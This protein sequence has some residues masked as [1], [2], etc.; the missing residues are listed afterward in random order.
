MTISRLS[1][2]NFKGVGLRQTVDLAPITLLFGPNSAGKSTIL[3]ALNYLNDI[4]CHLDPGSDSTHLGEG[5]LDLGGFRQFVHKHDLGKT[6]V[7]G[8]DLNLDEIDLY[9]SRANRTYRLHYERTGSD[10]RESA[11][12]VDISELTRNINRISFD[13]RVAWSDFEQAPYVQRMDIAF[14]GHRFVTIK[15]SSDGKR[16]NIE[17]LN[18]GIPVFRRG[19]SDIFELIA[20]DSIT[21]RHLQ[22]GG[23]ALIGIETA[24]HA[25][26]DWRNPL[27]I[28]DVW[29]E[30]R[31]YPNAPLLIDAA[32]Q[33][34]IR[35]SLEALAEELAGL[36]YL[37]PLRALPDRN[38]RPIA[39]NA[40]NWA[41]G[42]G[43][44]NH[45]YR[46]PNLISSVNDWFGNSRLKTGYQIESSD[47]LELEGRSPLIG[48]LQATSLDP[49]RG[50]IQEELDRTFKRR[51]LMLRDTNRKDTLVQLNDVGVGISQVLPVVVGAL[52]EDVSLYSI[53][54]P[55]IHIHPRL[56][57]G[58]GDLLIHSAKVLGKRFLIE[59]HSEH[60]ILRLLKRIREA[61]ELGEEDSSVFSAEDISVLYVECVE[62]ETRISPLRISQT[63]R[64]IDRWPDGFFEERHGE[65][66]A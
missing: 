1:I 20:V 50:A 56:Q 51:R 11:G 13:F 21:N 12:L 29:N 7:I 25:I 62:E 33:C 35:G 31:S 27:E 60:V 61:D 36:R 63:G 39:G 41:T 48:W 42:L 14:E 45:L 30:D 4:V 37:G 46:N 10:K 58:L 53:E 65:L 2:E 24:R 55:E 28:S 54:Q 8:I 40:E 19:N 43:A 15:A 23:H 32:L 47:V 26:P 38:Y 34:L 6:V 44:W 49:N 52:A 9:E 18:F 57:V 59:T 5:A 22:E 16:T 66:D 64:F 3:H 17:F